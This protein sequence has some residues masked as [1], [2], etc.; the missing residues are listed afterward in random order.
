MPAGVVQTLKTKITAPAQCKK[1]SSG[2]YIN[3][4]SDEFNYCYY[5]V[6]IEIKQIDPTIQGIDKFISSYK[7][8]EIS[9]LGNLQVECGPPNIENFISNLNVDLTI[10]NTSCNFISGLLSDLTLQQSGRSQTNKVNFENTITLYTDN[11][12]N[13][14]KIFATASTDG[15]SSDNYQ[16]IYKTKN[17]DNVKFLLQIT[18]LSNNYNGK[19]TETYLQAYYTN[20]LKLKIRFSKTLLSQ[21]F[22]GSNNLFIIYF[23][24]DKNIT[25]DIDNANVLGIRNK[26]DSDVKITFKP[27]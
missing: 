20:D 5:E 23:G 15:L 9:N 18:K 6:E 1:G 7:T 24:N 16:N 27:R 12:N 17:S 8:I 11:I 13:E 3:L 21:L 25:I 14:I 4:F 26:S 2:N 19:I 22:L 10:G